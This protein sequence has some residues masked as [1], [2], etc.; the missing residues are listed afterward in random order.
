MA[1]TPSN[2]KTEAD[3]RAER[4]ASQQDALLR[5]V[6]EAVRQDEFSTLAK[7]YGMPV[8]GLVLAG[9]LAFGGWLWWSDMSEA[10]L[11][12]SSEEVVRAMDQLE[13]DN[14]KAAD[15]AFAAILAEDGSAGAKIVA[16]LAR[17]GIAIQQDKLEEAA[18]LYAE[19]AADETAPQAY[20]DLATVREVSLRYDDMGTDAVV[21]RL[22]PLAMPGAPFF[23][24][25]GELLGAAYMDQGKDNLAGPLFAQIAKDENTP[26]SLRSRARQLA[27]LLGV[28]AIEDVD[29]TLEQLR[30]ESAAGAGN[31]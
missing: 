30:E 1:L 25:A 31:Q 27:A 17:A 9:L 20:R 29:E 6:D 16:K 10:K 14:P 26:D 22:K 5:E 7:R 18:N 23:G 8:G 12:S 2:T 13:A 24:S 28:D 3:K 4:D 21:A 15:D 19:V 11:E